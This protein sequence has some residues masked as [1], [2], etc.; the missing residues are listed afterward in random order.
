MDDV[1]NL[2]NYYLKS[3]KHGI[4]ETIARYMLVFLD[5]IPQ[6]RAVDVAK[7]AHTSASSV[8]R[9][10]RELGYD[11]YIEFK[12]VVDNYW[13]NVQ[14]KYLVPH[15]ALNVLGTDDEY[16]NSLKNWIEVV[17]EFVFCAMLALDRKQL[18][19]LATELTQYRYVYIFGAGLSA[20]IA[21]SLRIRLA[22][23]GKIIMTMVTPHMDM[24]LT[25]SREETLAVVISQ[26][27][28]V[29]RPGSRSEGLLEYLQ[30]HCAK[31]WLV[32]QEDPRK[33]FH[34]DEIIHIIPSSNFEVECHTMAYFEAI[35]GEYCRVLLEEGHSSLFEKSE[36]A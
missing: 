8:V 25:T 33:T 28:R 5:Q 17:Q 1:Y 20:Q 27:G 35:L 23:C 14:D 7:L 21:E 10:C 26:H 29:M 32:T 12:D 16:T 9:F 18:M 13:Q 30:K 22:R 6:M 19:R 24:P 34:A 11:G 15:I 4:N 3:H 31:T 36:H 2:L